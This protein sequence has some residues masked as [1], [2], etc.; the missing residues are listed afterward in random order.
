MGQL[1]AKATIELNSGSEVSTRG[2]K[3]PRAAGEPRADEVQTGG[4]GRQRD[5]KMLFAQVLE[6]HLYAVI[7][8]FLE[9]GAELLAAVRAAVEELTDDADG[10]V[11]L[12]LQKGRAAHVDGAV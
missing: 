1:Q 11:W 5:G 9:V 6:G 10:R 4:A 2:K 8:K 7:V 12:T 3:K